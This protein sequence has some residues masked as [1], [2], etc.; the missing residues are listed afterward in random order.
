MSRT[1]PSG[2]GARTWSPVFH[3]KAYLKRHKPG[4]LAEYEYWDGATW[5]DATER[6][7]V[8]DFLEADKRAAA[9]GHGHFAALLQ[10]AEAGGASFFSR[11][12][13]DREEE[14]ARSVPPPD[15]H[16]PVSRSDAQARWEASHE[17]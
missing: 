12:H 14:S 8:F 4:T 5:T 10:A 13:H 9:L 3:Q 16:R 17:S 7:E 2:A 15:L 1:A 11:V 6:A